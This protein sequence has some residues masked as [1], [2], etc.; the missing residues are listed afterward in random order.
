MLW[1][2]HPLSQSV[3][4]T[5]ETVSAF[6]EEG[7]RAHY[8]ALYQPGNMVLALAGQLEAPRAL[9]WVRR[10]FG[11]WAPAGGSAN[12][13][14]ALAAPPP[15]PMGRN[16]PPPLRVVPDADNQLRLQL[17]FPV[18]GYRS[19]DE[20]PLTLL[21]SVLDDGPNSRL[22]KTIREELAL[23]YYIGCGYTAYCDAGQIDITTAVAPDR[24][25]ALLGALFPLLRDLRER[26]VREAE[27]EAVKRRYRFGLEFSRDSLDAAVDRFAWPLLFG[28][29][30]EES[31]EWAR[32]ETTS[33][34]ALSAL[35]R[36]AL[37]RE[38]LHLA[39]V[40][41]VEDGTRRLL[42]SYLDQY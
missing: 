25:D 21:A 4:G 22:Q 1:P 40:G 20:V 7:V 38:R 23:V 28:E 15:L 13:G 35:A 17:S 29:V 32:V 36:R 2:G 14:P 39:V 42:R 9:E 6:T 19:D 31:E 30:R 41:P 11:G 8:A 18:A 10:H 12:G 33:A 5:R 34:E 24:L 3:T 16:G 37:A 27:L 26:G